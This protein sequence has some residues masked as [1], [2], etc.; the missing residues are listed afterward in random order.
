MWDCALRYSIL[1]ITVFFFATLPYHPRSNLLCSREQHGESALQGILRLYA[2]SGQSSRLLSLDQHTT[3]QEI[4]CCMGL[5]FVCC[6]SLY[7]LL[8]PCVAQAVSASSGKRRLRF[9]FPPTTWFCTFCTHFRYKIPLRK[10]SIVNTLIKFLPVAPL[11][12]WH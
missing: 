8:G 10:N 7:I 3:C 2:P 12:L 1:E 4:F 11:D 5:Y 9:R 6:M